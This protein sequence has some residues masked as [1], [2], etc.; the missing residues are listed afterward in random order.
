VL[1]HH[2]FLV[3]G[4]RITILACVDGPQRFNLAFKNWPAGNFA[5]R[6]GWTVL[7]AF[8]AVDDPAYLLSFRSMWA[9]IGFAGVA[10]C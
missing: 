3:L 5:I 2:I 1:S 4:S 7:G 6:C 10:C 9:T 8:S